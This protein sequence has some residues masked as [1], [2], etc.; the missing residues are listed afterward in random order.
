MKQFSKE[1]LDV[2]KQYE[3]NF[4]RAVNLNYY[5]NMTGK[6]LDA[7]AAVYD[8][9]ADKSYAKN[10]SCSHCILAFLQSVGNKYFKDLE[11]YKNNAAK[12]VEALDQVFGE[13][14]DEEP[15]P[16]PKK[17]IKKTVKDNGNKETSNKKRTAK[18]N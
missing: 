8:T 1:Q 18:K 16:T 4:N 12:L 14:P 17:T 5:R 6:A 9:V 11:A 7:I 10:W 15:E 2:L 3:D 13:V